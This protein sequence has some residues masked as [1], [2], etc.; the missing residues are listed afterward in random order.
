MT[1][2]FIEV[3]AGAGGM[4][5]GFMNSGMKPVMLIDNDKD[6]CKT[7]KTNHPDVDVRCVDMKTI[8]LSEYKDTIDVLCGGIPCQSWS[9]AGNRGGVDDS[10]GHLVYTFRDLVNTTHPKVFVIE[11]VKGMTTL[12]GGQAFR[13]ILDVL[14]C[15]DT[16]TINYQILNANDYGVAQ[17]RERLIIIGV[18]KDLNLEYTFPTKLEYKPVLRDILTDVPESVGAEYSDK[19][20]EIFKLVPEGGCWVDLPEEIQREYMG[21]SFFSGG[22]KRGIAK[23]L[24][25]SQPSLTLL[26]SPQQKQ[27][28]RCHPTEL[29]PLNVREYARI[30]SFPDD[31]VFEGSVNSQYKQIGN[32]VPVELAYHVGKNIIEMLKKTPK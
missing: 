28:E 10:R 13:E 23:R 30:Q 1:H 9:Q 15:E 19:K 32:A 12:N 17:K 4:S 25:M 27:T 24:S 8:D 31:F 20:K 22:G 18:R 21:K 14:K 5:L 6:S 7:L 3:C 29:R 2:Q 16:Y 26:C 11:N